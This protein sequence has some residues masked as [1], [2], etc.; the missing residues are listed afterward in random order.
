[1]AASTIPVSAEENLGDPIDIRVDI[2]HPEPVAAVAFP[3]AAIVRT[4]AQ[5]GEAIRGI[6]EHLLGVP[7]QEELTALRFRADIAEAEN[8]SL[9]ARIKTTEAIE[10]ITRNHERQARVKIEQQLAAVQESQRQDREDFRKL[11]ELVTIRVFTWIP[12]RLN[13]LKKGA[14][15]KTAMEIRYFLDFAR[16][17]TKRISLGFPKIAKSIAKLTQ[18]KVKQNTK[19]AIWSGWYNHDIL[20]GSGINITMIVVTKTLKTQR[21]NDTIWVIVDRLTKSAIISPMRETYSVEKLARMYLK[22]KVLGTSLDIS[23]AY[24]PQTNRQSKRT[25]QNLEDML[26]AYVIDFGNGWVKHFPLVEFSYNNSYHAS[27]KGTQ[28]EPLYGQKYH[29]PVYWA[30]LDEIHIDD[31]LRFVEE[32]VVG[33]YGEFIACLD[34]G[35][36]DTEDGV[37]VFWIG[38]T[39]IWLDGLC[40]CVDFLVWAGWSFGVDGLWI[41]FAFWSFIGL[42]VGGDC[43]M[44]C[45]V[46]VG[47]GVCEWLGMVVDWDSGIVGCGLVSWFGGVL[48]EVFVEKLVGSWCLEFGVGFGDELEWSWFLDVL[49]WDGDLGIVSGVDDVMGDLVRSGNFGLV[50]GCWVFVDGFGLEILVYF[51]WAFGFGGMVFGACLEWMGTGGS[52]LIVRRLEFS[53]WRFGYGAGWGFSWRCWKSGDLDG[54]FGDLWS[55][56]GGGDGLVGSFRCGVSGGGVRLWMDG[57]DGLLVGFLDGEGVLGWLWLCLEIGVYW[58][59]DRDFGFGVVECWRWIGGVVFWSGGFGCVGDIVWSLEMGGL[60]GGW[61]VD[62]WIFFGGLELEEILGDSFGK[63]WGCGLV[64][65]DARVGGGGSGFRGDWGCGDLDGGSVLELV[66][67]LEVLYSGRSWRFMDVENWFGCGGFGW[68]DWIARFGGASGFSFDL[69]GGVGVECLEGAWSVRDFEFGFGLDGG[70]S[71]DF[72]WSEIGWALCSGVWREFGSFGYYGFGWRCLDCGWIG[73]VWSGSLE[74]GFEVGFVVGMWTWVEFG[75]SGV[76]GGVVD[77]DLDAIGSC[78]VVVWF[79]EWSWVVIGGGLGVGDWRWMEL[80]CLWLVVG[81]ELDGALEWVIWMAMACCVELDWS[82]DG[83]EW[84]EF[85][86]GCGVAWSGSCLELWFLEIGGWGCWFWRGSGVEKIGGDFCWDWWWMVEVVEVRSLE[87]VVW[88]VGFFGWSVVTGVWVVLG[89][90][91]LVD[92]FGFLFW[93]SLVSAIRA[94][95]M[96]EIIMSGWLDVLEISGGGFVMIVFWFC[97]VLVGLGG[98][99]SNWMF[100]VVSCRDVGVG[101]RLV[102]WIGRLLEWWSGCW[103][104]GVGVWWRWWWRLVLV[105]GVGM[106]EEWSGRMFGWWWECLGVCGIGWMLAGGFFCLVDWREWSLRLEWDLDGGVGPIMDREEAKDQF[107]EKLSEPLRKTAPRQVPHLEPCGQGSVRWIGL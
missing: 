84:M 56:V 80:C 68:M 77:G 72:C 91:V 28:F 13:P 62:L 70:W 2:I 4:Q 79:C 21:G 25:I 47:G 55:G 22:E 58:C 20:N 95:W 53:Q 19:K 23:I 69:V 32:P 15:P 94:C 96:G 7:I 67:M 88:V 30:K 33:I 66:G 14:S 24:H 64:D 31:K 73:F 39:W 93:W 50:L 49:D 1:M 46:T 54:G 16:F 87:L 104:S 106:V 40:G 34:V 98:A 36:E 38:W 74:V 102:F 99:W 44:F 57:G 75:G 101:W 8:A 61:L 65:L 6:Q 35:L 42:G 85:L 83:V 52:E 105:F 86:R 81:V 3:A 26:R 9:R 89:F 48:L 82:L 63:F 78:G 100:F 60:D 12:P 107:W 92:W 18:R 103:R 27:I 97:G 29:S 10:K 17:I 41:G 11:K 5:H 51:A 71:L 59:V 90:L 76:D 45:G 37:V 43:W